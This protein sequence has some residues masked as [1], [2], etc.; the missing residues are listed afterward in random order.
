MQKWMIIHSDHEFYRES[1]RDYNII[2]K[3]FTYA[4]RF[5]KDKE[6]S[7][8][9]TIDSFVDENIEKDEKPEVLKDHTG[10]KVKHLYITNY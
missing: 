9:P 4:Q 6:K 7:Q 8:A 5:G 2:D 10:A 3:D 1:Y